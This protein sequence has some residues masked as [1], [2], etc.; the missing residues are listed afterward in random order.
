MRSLLSLILSLALVGPAIALEVI[1]SEHRN[2]DSFKRIS[3]HITGKENEGRYTIV[4]TDANRR[5]GFYI[6][7]KVQNK[8][9]HLT[10][11]AVRISHVKPGSMETH[12]QTVRIMSKLKKRMLIGFTNEEWE[13]SDRIPLAW[14]VEL[15]NPAG[16]A[17]EIAE[18][19][20]WSHES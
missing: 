20:L 15:I 13:T 14:K 19:F 1:S 2:D 6:A 10:Y 17:V 16:E 18:S 8:K 3:E 12:T 5:D 11:D 4:R 7:L 9:T